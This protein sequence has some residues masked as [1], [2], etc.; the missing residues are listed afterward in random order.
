MES[1][2][3]LRGWKI[4]HPFLLEFKNPRKRGEDY[5]HHHF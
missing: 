2:A 1:M 4:N 5:V 3:K